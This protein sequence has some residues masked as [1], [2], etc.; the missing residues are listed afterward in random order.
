MIIKCDSIKIWFSNKLSY[1]RCTITIKIAFIETNF[2]F[3]ANQIQPKMK[4]AQHMTVI[5]EKKMELSKIHQWS[6]DTKG[7]KLNQIIR[8]NDAKVSKEE[9]LPPTIIDVRS[10]WENQQKDSHRFH[11]M[12]FDPKNRLPKP[13]K[14]NIAPDTA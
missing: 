8:E 3:T 2:Y 5:R 9:K 10:H 13:W 7:M 6:K 12:T 11:N 4:T 1:Y 14:Q